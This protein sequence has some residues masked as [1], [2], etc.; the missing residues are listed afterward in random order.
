MREVT[1]FIECIPDY[2]ETSAW[3]GADRQGSKRVLEVHEGLIP[4]HSVRC[5]FLQI[6]AGGLL[7]GW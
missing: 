2:E 6:L 1:L 4:S 7:E 5:L 3:G